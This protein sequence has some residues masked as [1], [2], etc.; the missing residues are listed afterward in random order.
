MTTQPDAAAAEFGNQSL[1]HRNN[2]PP[3]PPGAISGPTPI[4][5]VVYMPLIGATAVALLRRVGRLFAG[6]STG[7]IQVDAAVLGGLG[8]R[9]GSTEA[10]GERSSLMKNLGRLV[11]RK[12]VTRTESRHFHRLSERIPLD[13]S[14]RRR[15]PEYVCRIH[16]RYVHELTTRPMDGTSNAN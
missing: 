16:Q 10:V 9:A 13:D 1:L 15:I 8:L 4:P 3:N 14:D 12:L 5:E 7:T 6:S 11:R 2:P